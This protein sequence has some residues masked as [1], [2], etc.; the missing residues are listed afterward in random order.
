MVTT[1]TLRLGVQSIHSQWMTSPVRTKETPEHA[2]N[3]RAF[4]CGGYIGER[5]IQVCI[6]MFMFVTFASSIVANMW[7]KCKEMRVKQGNI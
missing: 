1:A 5:L 7:H 3:T 4:C 2:I 6:K